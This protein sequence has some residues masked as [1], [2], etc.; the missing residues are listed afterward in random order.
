MLV[1]GTRELDFGFGFGFW[2]LGVG[3]WESGFDMLALLILLAAA[4]LVD[5]V[6]AGDRA[7][8]I[9]MIERR[10]DVNAAEADG[11]TALHWAVQRNDLDLVERLIRA[12][13]N[14]KAKNEY[15]ASPMSEAA[16]SGNAAG[17]WKMI[18][19]GAEVETPNAEGQTALMVIERTE[20]VDAA[21]LL[22]SSGA[23]VYTV[24][25]WSRQTAQMWETAKSQPTMVKELI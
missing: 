16:V 6:K 18:K 13:A 4:P 21:R 8:A 1:I 25:R 22:R 23:A 9:A 17:T 3:N 5:A 24:E 19:C 12:G 10:V 15:S 11:T 7:A 20:Q 2:D 14:A